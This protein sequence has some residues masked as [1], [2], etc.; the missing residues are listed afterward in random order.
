MTL[1]GG[2]PL[3]NTVH[4][5]D[6][7]LSRK[8]VSS[9]SYSCGRRP[10]HH[11][12]SKTRIFFWNFRLLYYQSLIGCAKEFPLLSTVGTTVFPPQGLSLVGSAV[13]ASASSSEQLL[14]QPRNRMAFPLPLD[15]KPFQS[16]STWSSIISFQCVLYCFDCLFFFVEIKFELRIYHQMNCQDLNVNVFSREVGL[17]LKQ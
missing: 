5:C 15:P 7:S 17:S 6:E 10:G 13:V 16:S 14:G 4:L 9:P 8:A 3:E 12:Q 1:K 11:R 2:L